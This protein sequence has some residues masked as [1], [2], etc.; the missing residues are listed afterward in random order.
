MLD[1]R[2]CSWTFMTPPDG[3]VTFFFIKKM[4]DR[5]VV[6][7]IMEN[8]INS[9]KKSTVRNFPYIVDAKKE[10]R[11]T[12]RKRRA[13][14]ETE[15]IKQ[16][17]LSSCYPIR[18]RPVAKMTN[19]QATQVRST[20]W[21]HKADCS[22]SFASVEALLIPVEPAE[23]F[24]FEYYYSHPIMEDTSSSRGVLHP[25]A[26]TRIFLLAL[27]NQQEIA[28]SASIAASQSDHG[29]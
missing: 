21:A 27:S 4:A 8:H 16:R 6:C 22:G 24:A 5:S 23:R 7:V 17:R 29:P 20:G 2:T 25:G 19:A 28:V 18:S 9:N 1:H 15:Q 10:S 3:S 13:R 26:C 11:Y 14:N 12:S